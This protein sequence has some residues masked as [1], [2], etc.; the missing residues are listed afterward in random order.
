MW[1]NI[2]GKEKRGERN[3]SVSTVTRQFYPLDIKMKISVHLMILGALVALCLCYDSSESNE[4]TEDLF[5]N[6]RQANS[7]I[8]RPGGNALRRNNYNHFNRRAMKSPAERRT[9]ICEDYY[10]CRTY[11]YRHGYQS[12]YQRYFAAQN[13]RV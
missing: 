3:T 5:V 12:A 7:F 4:S 9:E 13:R 8:S 2:T 1:H 10:P 11:A 6:R